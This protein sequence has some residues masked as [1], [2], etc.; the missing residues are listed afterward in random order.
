VVHVRGA[1]AESFARVLR[2]RWSGSVVVGDPGS[3]AA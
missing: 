3:V 1:G 2:E